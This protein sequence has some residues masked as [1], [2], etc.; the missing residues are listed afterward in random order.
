MPSSSFIIA[1][2]YIP[3]FLVKLPRS[4]PVIMRR[5][6][7]QPSNKSRIILLITAITEVTDGVTCLTVKDDGIGVFEIE[8]KYLNANKEIK[9]GHLQSKVV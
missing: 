6:M 4:I 5:G 9:I 2:P 7:Q 1:D 3:R 8:S